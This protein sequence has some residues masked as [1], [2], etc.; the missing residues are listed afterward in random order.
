MKYR[1]GINYTFLLLALGIVSTILSTPISAQTG[2]NSQ[3]QTGTTSGSGQQ[4]Q[5]GQGTAPAIGSIEDLKKLT[6]PEGPPPK[7]SNDTTPLFQQLGKETGTDNQTAGQ[8]QQQQQ[9]GNQTGQ[10]QQQGGQQQEGNQTAG[11]AGGQ[12]PQPSEQGQQ[13][14]EGNQ[15]GQQQEGNE[16]GG[17]LSEVG[18]AIGKLFQ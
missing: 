4:Q 13:Q 12:Q 8:G 17:P 2:G 18:E 9:G 6:T 14:Q 1:T 11:T 5:G 7:T 16:T 15:T 10:G 3:N